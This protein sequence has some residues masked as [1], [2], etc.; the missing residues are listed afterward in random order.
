MCENEDEDFSGGETVTI[1]N[2]NQE[3][4]ARHLSADCRRKVFEVIEEF[5]ELG[6]LN[7]SDS[8]IE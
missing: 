8:R 3:I 4:L 6:Y 7:R 5:A 1:P 2:S